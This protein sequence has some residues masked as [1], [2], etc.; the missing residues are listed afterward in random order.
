MHWVRVRGDWRGMAC[1]L[2][3][4][5]QQREQAPKSFG[6]VCE[7]LACCLEVLGVCAARACETAQIRER[8][9]KRDLEKKFD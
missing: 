2:A 4:G 5:V 9:R 3:R 1:E 8:A 7:K 6:L